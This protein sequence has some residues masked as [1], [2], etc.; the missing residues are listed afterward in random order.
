MKILIIS[1]TTHRDKSTS[2][3]ILT[4]LSDVLNK[5]H[6]IDFI[7]ANDLHIVPNLSCYSDGKM[8]CAHPDAGEYRCWAHK[9]S[10]DNPDDY[11]G[12]D[13]M[14]II[15]DAIEWADVVLW[16]TSVRWG[17]HSALLQKIIERMNN[18]ENR[19]TAYGEK[20]PLEG[21]KC[22]IIVTGHV[23]KVQAVA[24]HLSEVFSIIGFDMH[25]DNVFTWQ[26]SLDPRLEQEDDNND[27]LDK[28]LKSN[29]GKRQVESFLKGLC[30]DI[31]NDVIVS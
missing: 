11:R 17:S 20:N 25:P 27:P 31:D 3:M 16:G 30:G 9:L 15:Y 19:K 10:H 1:T 5:K 22:G 13:E 14:S 26:R 24:Y 6:N 4:K 21:K 2:K 28:F 18:L 7:D 8:N 12:K 29:E 23:Y